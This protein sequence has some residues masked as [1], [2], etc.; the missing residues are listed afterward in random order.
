MVL[1]KMVA[2]SSLEVGDDDGKLL[3]FSLELAVMV[4]VMAVAKSYLSRQA[5]GG[6]F[7]QGLLW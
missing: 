2:L 6:A 5:Q 4:T 3:L 1:V 7:W